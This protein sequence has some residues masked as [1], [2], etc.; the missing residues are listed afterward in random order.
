M[1]HRYMSALGHFLVLKTIIISSPQ[2]GGVERVQPQKFL[3]KL[4]TPRA[5]IVTRQ[6]NSPRMINALQVKEGCFSPVIQS[7]LCSS[8]FRLII[9]GEEGT[10]KVTHEYTIG[11]EADSISAS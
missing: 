3:A 8:T 9:C 2:S 5:E 10:F 1:F 6:M 7:L 11:S 4:L